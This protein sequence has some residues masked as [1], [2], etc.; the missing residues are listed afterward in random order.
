MTETHL[1]SLQNPAVKLIRSLADRKYR[2]ETGLFVAEGE[3]VLARARESGWEPELVVSNGPRPAW[4]KARMLTAD[5][6]VMAALSGQ[7][8]ASAAVAAFRQRWSGAAV[9]DGT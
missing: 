9:P 8:N 5:G 6:K 2:Q 7:A 4:G 3:K 1:T